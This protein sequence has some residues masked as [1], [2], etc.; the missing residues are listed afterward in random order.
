RSILQSLE[1][2]GDISEDIAKK[3][4]ALKDLGGKFD[5][6]EV[7]R[8]YKIG[9]KA[10][11]IVKTSVECIFTGD[12]RLANS[13]LEMRRSLKNE[14]EK[15]FYELPGVP[16]LRTLISCISNIIHIGSMNAEIAINKALR[17][18]SSSVMEIV[19]VVRH[20]RVKRL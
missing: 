17:E 12:I 7:E 5:K 15:I 20:T 4:I 8:I 9:E 10:Q 6:E 14:I 3:I 19:E 13:I 18:R 2:I 16:Y 11:E 1:L